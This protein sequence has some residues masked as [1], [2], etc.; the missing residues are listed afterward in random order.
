MRALTLLLFFLLFYS[1]QDKKTRVI[2]KD[3]NESRMKPSNNEFVNVSKKADFRLTDKNVMEF[4][5]DYGS[6]T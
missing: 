2:T 6:K 3:V 1:C 5:L 4:L